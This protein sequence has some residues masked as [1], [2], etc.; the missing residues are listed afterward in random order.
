MARADTRLE[1]A[2]RI[3]PVTALRM[4]SRVGRFLRPYRAQVVAATTLNGTPVWDYT[5]ASFAASRATE[6]IDG[7]V[8]AK[9]AHLH[10]PAWIARHPERHFLPFLAGLIDTDGTVGRERHD[11]RGIRG[12]LPRRRPRMRDVLEGQGDRPAR[13]HHGRKRA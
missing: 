9:T 13:I 2:P 6:L 3:P 1:P 10:V 11:R 7:Q 4:V 8:G 5:V 12:G